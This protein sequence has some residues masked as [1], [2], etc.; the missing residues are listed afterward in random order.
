M[1][2]QRH[3]HFMGLALEQGKRAEELGNPPIGSLLVKNE[4]IVGAGYNSVISGCD[5]TA[6]AEMQAIR[7]ASRRLSTTDLSGCTCYTV[8]EPCP[9]CCWALVEANVHRIVLG[10]RH[11]GMKK[12]SPPARTDY[13]DYGVENLLAM[14]GKSIEL[15][16]G[17]RT[18]ECERNRSD[19]RPK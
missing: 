1:D 7:D 19:W 18:L 9:M 2:T 11:S 17:I 3:E 14:T 8:M 12:F 4:E 5:P 6:H 16:V 10:A 13:G 15:I